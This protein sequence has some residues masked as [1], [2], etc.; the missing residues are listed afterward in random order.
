M[1]FEWIVEYT[2]EVQR[3]PWR[4]GLTRVAILN[5]KVDA[6]LARGSPPV[7]VKLKQTKEEREAQCA[8]PNLEWSKLNKAKER[9]RRAKQERDIKRSDKKVKRWWKQAE[10][11]MDRGDM[12]MVQRFFNKI[13]EQERLIAGTKFEKKVAEDTEGQWTSIEYH[14]PD[15]GMHGD[16]DVLTAD[17]VA[18]ECKCS[19]AAGDASQFYKNQIAAPLIFGAGTVTHVAVPAGQSAATLRRHFPND[20]N[21]PD[22]MQEH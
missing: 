22:K 8:H 19:A 17:G 16:I 5:L 20:P 6:A 4:V 7:V 1:G 2:S 12:A 15:C 10:K 18:K 21:M 13:A 11:A 14:C 9:R 3:L